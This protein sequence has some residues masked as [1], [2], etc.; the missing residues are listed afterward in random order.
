MRNFF[1]S[2]TM[3]TE[4]TF[5]GRDVSSVYY[6]DKTTNAT[7]YLPVL[8]WDK[9]PGFENAS[10][11]DIY[12]LCKKKQAGT[13]K[14]WPEDIKLG[15][16]KNISFRWGNENSSTVFYTMTFE[17]IGIDIDGPG[18]LT[19]MSL[20]NLP[21][22]PTLNKSQ[23]INLSFAGRPITSI[24]YD[25][26]NILLTFLRDFPIIQTPQG[27]QE[28]WGDFVYL[29]DFIKPLR[30]QIYNPKTN[31][32][33]VVECKLWDIS[34]AEAGINCETPRCFTEGVSTPYFTTPPKRHFMYS[35]DWFST[36]EIRYGTRE[37]YYFGDEYLDDYDWQPAIGY[38]HSIGTNATD[39][40]V[41]ELSWY[42]KYLY[43]S[44]PNPDPGEGWYMPANIQGE[45]IFNCPCFAIG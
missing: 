16:T 33:E 25:E 45:L 20:R 24:P 3:P 41:S 30:K 44:N 32:V 18:V 34:C 42:N 1:I 8:V 17:I 39:L 9:W 5:N 19:F 13:I 10:W 12:D 15:A 26:M 23:T 37:L 21:A 35:K 22:E 36:K 40:P 4:I 31:T 11:K 27:A 29:E 2:N 28:V 7:N 38:A 14:T 43:V 6:T